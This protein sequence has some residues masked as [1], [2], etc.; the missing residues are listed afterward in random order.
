MP[1]SDGRVWDEGG[2]GGR[3]FCRRADGLH[4]DGSALEL[5]FPLRVGTSESHGGSRQAALKKAPK[6]IRFIFSP[7]G[8]RVLETNFCC[9]HSL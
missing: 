3:I 5:L 8:K 9:R 6:E 2:K 4:E 7:I 1:C